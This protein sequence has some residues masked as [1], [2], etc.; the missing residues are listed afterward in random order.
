VA[1]DHAKAFG[2]VIGKALADVAA[3]Q[4]TAEILVMSR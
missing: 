2:C 4:S 3:G 1:T